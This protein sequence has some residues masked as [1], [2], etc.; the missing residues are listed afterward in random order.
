MWSL[1]DSVRWLAVTFSYDGLIS[2]L[3][4]SAEQM[5][6]FCAS[7]IVG[8]PITQ[9]LADRSVFEV[10]RMMESAKER[11]SWEG[12]IVHLN[13]SGISFEAEGNLSTL[14]GKENPRAGFIL[15]S[16]LVG[17]NSQDACEQAAQREVASKLRTIAHE[18]NNPLAVMMGFAQLI[19]LNAQ[20]S[21]R[22]RADM[23]KLFS[24]LKR[25]IQVVERLHSYA[26][27]LQEGERQE[28]YLKSAGA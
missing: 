23:E 6:G 18:M 22:V 28:V 13:R 20:C 12:K 4:P 16:T 19:M 21:G 26:L 10:A 9:I 11:G 25:V 14:A 27:S 24:E 7:E 17:Q 15:F 2:S 5:I 8:K 1:G 3:S